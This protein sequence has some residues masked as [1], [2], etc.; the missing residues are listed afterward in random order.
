MNKQYITYQEKE[1]LKREFV[2]KYLLLMIIIFLIYMLIYTFIQYNK[3][4][5]YY[6]GGGLV[7]HFD[8]LSHRPKKQQPGEIC[9]LLFHLVPNLYHIHH[10]VF[11]ERICHEFCVAFTPSDW[12][13]YI[14]SQ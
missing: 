13:L 12:C 1:R 7:S 10:G 6:I 11:L 8:S 5:A 4:L 9:T 3:F 2:H 14:L